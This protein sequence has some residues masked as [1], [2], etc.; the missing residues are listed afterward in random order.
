MSVASNAC[1]AVA[2]SLN[3]YYRPIAE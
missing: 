2:R 3:G 1:A